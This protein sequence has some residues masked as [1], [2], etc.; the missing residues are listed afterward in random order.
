MATRR[1]RKTHN[2]I[3][4]SVS[5]LRLLAIIQLHDVIQQRELSAPSSSPSPSPDHLRQQF[6][7][8]LE[9]MNQAA[10]ILAFDTRR[11]LCLKTA[12]NELSLENKQKRN[13]IITV[14]LGHA[15]KC[16]YPYGP[17]RYYD[18]FINPFIVQLPLFTFPRNAGRA[19]RLSFLSLCNG[20]PRYWAS[21][22]LSQT[23]F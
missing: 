19:T 22:A 11:G 10:C 4:I 15:A 18:G 12:T 14:L 17:S 16:K 8:T 6:N 13:I 23:S 21:R 2:T 7:D 9:M 20:S 3:S 1:R 5:D